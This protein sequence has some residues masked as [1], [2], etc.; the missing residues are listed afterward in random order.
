MLISVLVQLQAHGTSLLIFKM[1]HSTDIRNPDWK[2]LSAAG[3]SNT[4]QSPQHVLCNEQQVFFSSTEL[5]R[6]SPTFIGAGLASVTVVLGWVRV[7]RAGSRDMP[8]SQPASHCC[9][10]LSH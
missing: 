6:L 5:L 3:C 8:I 4:C 9:L 2:F 10:E 7:F 1:G